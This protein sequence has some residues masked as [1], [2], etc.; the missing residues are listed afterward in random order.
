MFLEVLLFQKRFIRDLLFRCVVIFLAVNCFEF[1]PIN[2]DYGIG[3]H[4]HLA[5]KLDECATSIFNAFAII[6]SEISNGFE[7][8]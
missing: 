1:T 7:V 8:G 5:A 6:F 4:I 3:K 2:G